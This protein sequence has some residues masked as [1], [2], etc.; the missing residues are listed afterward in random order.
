MEPDKPSP[1]NNLTVILDTIFWISLLAAG[2][3]AGYMLSM[4]DQFKETDTTL[5]V[6]T[7]ITFCGNKGA[8][9]SVCTTDIGGT[10]AINGDSQLQVTMKRKAGCSA[11]LTELGKRGVSA[12]IGTGNRTIN[13]NFNETTMDDLINIG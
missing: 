5:L 3:Y 10:S 9:Y 8:I 1:S 4:Q 2:V 12:R 11:I 6:N 13:V 7:L